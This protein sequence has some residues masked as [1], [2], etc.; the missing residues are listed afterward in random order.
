M[1]FL[2]IVIAPRL[3]P[4]LFVL[5]GWR[6]PAVCFVYSF[7]QMAKLGM[8]VAAIVDEEANQ[9]TDS[10]YVRAVDDRSPIAGAPHQS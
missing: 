10:F 7:L 2:C 9:C 5:S 8:T 1:I 3:C 4:P 6:A